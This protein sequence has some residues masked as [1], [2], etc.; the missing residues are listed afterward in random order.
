MSEKFWKVTVECVVMYDSDPICWDVNAVLE[1]VQTSVMAGFGIVKTK[2]L[3][4]KVGEDQWRR[5]N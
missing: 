2:E 4:E 5:K 1:E 3:I